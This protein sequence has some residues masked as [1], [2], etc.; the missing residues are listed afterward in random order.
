MIATPVRRAGPLVLPRWPR[1]LSAPRQCRPRRRR[2][3]RSS[4][5]PA[6][7]GAGFEIDGSLQA[8]QQSTVAAQLGG[9]VLQLAVKAGD[10][11]EAGQLLA[12]IDERDAQAGAGA[13]RGRRGASRCRIA[14]CAAATPSATRELLAQGFISQAALD[15]AE[16]QLR[17]AQ[18]GLQQAQSGRAQAA[19]ARGFAAVTAP[20][21][22]VVL[23]TH[24]EAGEL[25]TPGRPLVTLYAPGRMRAVVQL[26]ASRSALARA[27][28]AVEVQLPDGRWVDAGRPHRTAGHRPGVADRRMAARPARG[29]QRR[30][31]A[32]PERARALR[33]RGRRGGARHAGPPDRAR[34]RACCA[35]AS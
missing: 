11:V 14:Q 10:R 35:A 15:V 25:A 27:A 29:G 21:A 19:L 28:A 4:S 12:R 5:A 18:A 9:N 13:Q 34:R 8:L 23:A 30:P 24:V 17:A 6:P 22:G 32:G 7:R 33:R 20:F 2:C 31:A 16:T 1:S 3:P 26:P